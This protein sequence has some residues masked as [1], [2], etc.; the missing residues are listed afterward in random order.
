MTEKGGDPQSK[1]DSGD[2]SQCLMAGMFIITI[3]VMLDK[4]LRSQL[5]DWIDPYMSGLV[6]FDGMY[7]ILTLLITGVTMALFS[8]LVRNYFIDWVSMAKN[9]KFGSALNKELREATTGNNTYKMKKL[10]EVQQA[11]AQ[12]QLMDSTSQMK[13]MVF[14]MIII[15]SVFTWLWIFVA[16]APF[17]FY[18]VPWNAK[19]FFFQKGPAGFMPY[20]I[21]VYS[22][23]SIPF[24]QMFQ[25]MTKALSYKNRIN[26]LEKNTRD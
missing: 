7:P 24:G 16:N 11:H 18:S 19:V 9:Q 3:M 22:V 21:W 14:T 13:P 17:Q 23:L 5:G 20:W 8:T 6:G 15:I 10:K 12:K 1:Q 26:H 2:G 4:D 25:H